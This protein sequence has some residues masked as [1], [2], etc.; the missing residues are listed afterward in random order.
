ME[1]HDHKTM[2]VST[3]TDIRKVTQIKLANEGKKLK[4]RK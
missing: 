3:E 2:E 1:G 4:Y